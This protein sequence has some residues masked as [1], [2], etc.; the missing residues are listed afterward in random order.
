MSA[1]KPGAEVKRFQIGDVRVLPAEGLVFELQKEG[2]LREVAQILESTGLVLVDETNRTFGMHQLI[3]LA[4]GEVLGWQEQCERMQTLLHARCG[5]F[6]DERYLDFRSYSVMREVLSAA[7]AIVKRMRDFGYCQGEAW[8]SGMLLRLYEEAREIH[9]ND[10]ETSNLIFNAAQGSLIADLVFGH[11]IKGGHTAKERGMELKAILELPYIK[12]VADCYNSNLR[13]CL[14]DQGRLVIQ[15]D[16]SSVHAVELLEGNHGKAVCDRHLRTMRWRFHTLCGNKSSDENMLSE[17]LGV[18]NTED[19]ATGRWEVGVALGAAYYSVGVSCYQLD[20]QKEILSFE[21]SLRIRLDTLGEQHPDTASTLA[22]LAV[23]YQK[24]GKHDEE[25]S[26]TERALRIYNNVLGMHPET[27]NAVSSLGTSYH[28]IAKYN[29]AIQMLQEALHI[30]RNTVGMTHPFAADV[31]YSMS[32]AYYNMRNLDQALG[33]RLEALDIRR[34]TL[35]AE[36][37]DTKTAF[38]GLKMIVRKMHGSGVGKTPVDG[39]GTFGCFNGTYIGE[40]RHGKRQGSGKMQFSPIKSERT[41]FRQARNVWQFDPLL[42][43]P[44]SAPHPHSH[45]GVDYYLEYEGEWNS[46]VMHGR[47][48]AIFKSGRTYDGE[49][50]CGMVHGRGKCVWPNVGRVVVGKAIFASGRTYDGEF[51]CDMVHGRGKCVWPNGDEYEGEMNNDSIHGHG[52]FKQA[53]S[54]TA[55]GSDHPGNQ[56]D[57][58]DGF[59]QNG[60]RHG[61]CVYTFFNGEVFHC[62]WNNSRCPQFQDRLE[63]FRNGSPWN[64]HGEKK[65][66]NG[67]YVGNFRDGKRVGKGRMQFSNGDEYDGEW[68]DDFMHGR[69]TYKS[70]NGSYVGNF[71]DGKRVGKGRMQFSNDDEYDGE[72]YDDFMHGRGKYKSTGKFWSRV[73]VRGFVC[74]YD[75][76]FLNGKIHGRGKCVWPNGDEYEGEMKN[77]KPEKNFKPEIKSK[78]TA[79]AKVTFGFV[80]VHFIVRI[81]LTFTLQI[82]RC[83]ISS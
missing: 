18:Y 25:K 43:P 38:E 26:L 61:K 41:L 22:S 76:Q 4:V 2:Q 47:G 60:R 34:K 79:A 69:G 21:Q 32:T 9:G 15:D 73:F 42:P 39:S 53:A 71:R 52:V 65:F 5:Q 46:D 67:S 20:A 66:I 37:L 82:R 70:T 74:T 49:F 64:G 3:Q 45:L 14:I 68:Y 1:M 50:F 57:T 36:H 63:A 33:L 44:P 83:W 81:T 48:K 55:F 54:G 35:G 77:D 62:T 28:N 23:P 80:V 30:H 58:Y 72:W 10:T 31:I 13:Q 12:D 24:Q 29:E 7:F 19:E 40:L 78:I 51:F 59:W 75:G 17:I 8:C 6:G 27:A 16:G 56:G 11:L